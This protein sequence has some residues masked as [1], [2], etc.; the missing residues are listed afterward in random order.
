[1]PQLCGFEAPRPKD[2]ELEHLIARIEEDMD[3]WRD[4]RMDEVLTYIR[5]SKNLP[6][7][8]PEIRKLKAIAD[9]FLRT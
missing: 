2:L 6:S 1:M 3:L 5:G 8:Q 7:S 9:R 4:A